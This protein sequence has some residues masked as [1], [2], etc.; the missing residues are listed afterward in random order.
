MVVFLLCDKRDEAAATRAFC[1]K[2]IKRNGQLE[3]MVIDNNGANVS[4]LRNINLQLWLSGDEFN[5]I[6]VRQKK[7]LNKVIE[8]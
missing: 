2:T 1:D 5:Q 4:V 7:Y 8:R 3:N 6:T